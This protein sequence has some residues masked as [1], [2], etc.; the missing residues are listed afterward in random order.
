MRLWI[1]YQK[2]K[3]LDKLGFIKIKIFFSVKDSVKRKKRTKDWKEIFA[4]HISN[5]GLINRIQ[6]ELLKFNNKRASNPIKK[7][8]K[9]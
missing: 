7:C 2:G 9:S 6:K 1:W 5:K 4:N 8:T 3:K